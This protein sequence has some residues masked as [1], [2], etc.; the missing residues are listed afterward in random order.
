MHGRRPIPTDGRRACADMQQLR[1]EDGVVVSSGIAQTLIG[2]A[3]LLLHLNIAL[4]EEA[5]G[6]APQSLAALILY[7]E[8][9]A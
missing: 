1:H 7:I 4:V 6:N 3:A 2:H 5:N 9:E 8:E